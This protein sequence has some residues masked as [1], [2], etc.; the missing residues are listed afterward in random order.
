MIG[1]DDTPRNVLTVASL[2]SALLIRIFHKRNEQLLGVFRLCRPI[3]LRDLELAHIGVHDRRRAG[4]KAVSRQQDNPP[5]SRLPDLQSP[6]G[7]H[8][9]PSALS[10]C[11]IHCL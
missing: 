7:V 10:E 3:R 11:C 1:G 2:F 5:R 8:W 4:G 9:R 6:R